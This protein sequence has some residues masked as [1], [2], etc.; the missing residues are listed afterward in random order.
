M[1]TRR[2]SQLETHL[3]SDRVAN[4]VEVDT[5]GAASTLAQATQALD[6]LAGGDRER[7][8]D[9]RI[10][11]VIEGLN[12][13]R[14]SG[15]S[16]SRDRRSLKS[17]PN[18]NTRNMSMS[19]SLLT[20]VTSLAAQQNLNA[21]QSMLAASIGRLSS[22]MRINSASDDAAGLGISQSLSADIT[23]LAPGA[24]QRERRRSRCRRSRKAA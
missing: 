12:V 16:V 4:L 6:D 18:R 8:R 7:H 13:A 21:T 23:S 1:P 22:G 11:F 20:N 17:N 3:G 9:A 24:A 2:A 19:I 10:Q 14:E 15:E 5:V